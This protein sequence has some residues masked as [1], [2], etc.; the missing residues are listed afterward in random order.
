MDEFRSQVVDGP[1]GRVELFRKLLVSILE[2][3]AKAEITDFDRAIVLDQDVFG[4]EVSVGDVF[5]TAV[6]DGS[7]DLPKHNPSRILSHPL[8]L[9]RAYMVPKISPFN[10]LQNK[11]DFSFA[12]HD[13]EKFDH[14]DVLNHLHGLDLH[15][16]IIDHLEFP[17]P[18]F[19]DDF[20]RVL[21]PGLG[22]ILSQSDSKNG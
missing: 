18:L 3:G 15:D 13:L 21:L 9:K 10:I 20:N 11:I 14:I 7:D 1:T 6:V 8:P 22:S 17:D 2:E 16:Q 12:R 19:F 4:L 5:V